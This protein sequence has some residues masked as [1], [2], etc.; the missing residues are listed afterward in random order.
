MPLTTESTESYLDAV[1]LRGLCR[2]RGLTLAQLAKSA[3]LNYSHLSRPLQSLPGPPLRALAG[4]TLERLACVLKVP[5]VCLITTPRDP[6]WL[7][8]DLSRPGQVEEVMG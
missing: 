5:V 2:F 4:E 6:R 7:P 3:G 1:Q 8:V